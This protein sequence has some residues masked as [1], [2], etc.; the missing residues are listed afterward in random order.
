MII[1]VG[2]VALVGLNSFYTVRQDE[3]ALVLQFGS[4]VAVR[5]EYVTVDMDADPTEA[6]TPAEQ[7]DVPRDAPV[8]EV[9]EAGLFFKLPW[10]EVII[11]DRKN[12]GTNIP[13]IEVLAS[14]Q[15]RLTVDAFVRWRIVDPLKFYQR[16]RTE[17]GANAQLQRFTESN[18]R[19]ALGQVPVPEII[20]GQRASLMDEIRLNVN[21]ALAGTGIDIIDV[22]I[23]QAD[24]PAAVAEGVYER[25]KTERQQEAQ[26][27]RSEGEER[28]RLIRA[29]ADR[30]QT[31]IVAEANEQSETIRGEGDAR[32]N[33]IYAQAYGQDISFFRFQRAL[34]ACE[35]AI[36]EGT[37]VVA[38][39][40]TLD[41]CRVF[42]E[43]AEAAG[44]R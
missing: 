35:E 15:R 3:Q 29:Q 30:Q 5:N 28:A 27:I 11:L 8:Q 42:I 21:Q 16:L 33:N 25:M 23:R 41:L 7:Q 24:L 12:I 38:D 19:D 2:V 22:R 40:S 36:Q 43:Q 44:D 26:R 14:D 32:R 6:D 20:S 31:V 9:D 18:I 39:P 34:I 1:A 4:P 37:V 13:D 10:E 17:R